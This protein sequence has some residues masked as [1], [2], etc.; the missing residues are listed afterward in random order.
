MAVFGQNGGGGR[1]GGAGADDESVVVILF[2]MSSWGQN[3]HDLGQ[4]PLPGIDQ[5]VAAAIEGLRAAQ[6]KSG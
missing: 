6:V 1:P 5:R 3:F 4:R 2:F